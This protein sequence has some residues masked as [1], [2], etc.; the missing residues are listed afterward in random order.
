MSD[1][2]NEIKPHTA[3]VDDVATHFGVSAD[4]V[5]NWL[6]SKNPPPHRRVG[7]QYRFNLGEVDA[8]AAVKEAV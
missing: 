4:T 1:G 3:S 8:W 5:Y 7:R 2:S 6:K